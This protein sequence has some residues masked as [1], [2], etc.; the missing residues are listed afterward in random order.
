MDELKLGMIGLDTSH[1]PAFTRLLHD[2]ENPHHVAG[3]RVV[4]A[5]PGGSDELEVSY[6]RVDKFTAQMRDELGVEIKDS[7]E[8]ACEGVDAV[9]LESCDGRQHREQFETIAPYG[10]PVFIDKPLATTTDDAKRIVE[11]ADEHD[12]P[13]VS[14]SS[15]R[16]S[17]GVVELGRGQDVQGCAA[18]GPASIL[19]DFPGL[20]WYGIHVAEMIFAK[21][22]R[23]CRE[24]TVRKTDLADVATGVWDDG[25]VGVLYGHRIEKGPGFGC[26]VFY[27]G[28]VEQGVG[29]SEPPGY[30]LLLEP[31]LEFFRT[32]EP[33]V[34]PMET[35]EIVAFLE[36]ANQSRE[37][38]ETAELRVD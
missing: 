31:V 4:A 21:M 22:G 27:K 29:R 10:L 6:S 15:A 35:V 33:P 1:C 34:D 23:G 3:G 18:F 9:L 14:S 11:L 16:F 12:A 7:I 28:G 38:G 8:A 30:A 13:F 36:A 32:G 5:F 2:Q 26:S 37:S 20:F 19:D 25:R 24:V 17:R